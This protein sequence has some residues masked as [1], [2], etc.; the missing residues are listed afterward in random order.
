MRHPFSLYKEVKKSG[1]LWYARFWDETAQKY[2]RSRSTG[3]P[4]E[5]K[6]ER[7]REAEEAARRIY[8]ELTATLNQSAPAPAAIAPT[9]PAPQ[10]AQTA[11]PQQTRTTTAS[12][13]A[14]MPLTQYL[15]GFWTPTSEYAN[16]NRDV[17]KDPLTPYYIKS[18]HEDV[19][20]HVEP[21]P[22]FAGVTV[23]SLSKATLKKWLIWLASRKTQRRKKDGTLIEGDTLS[24]RRANKILQ[25][26]RVAVRW[27]V[28]NEEIP[29]DP[30]RK[31]GEV[32]DCYDSNCWERLV[33]WSDGTRE[34]VAGWT[35][36]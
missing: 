20:R 6:K 13:V 23:G 17:K 14:N 18:N 35:V 22:G 32:T 30:F 7:R 11:E 31:L 24:S 2:N 28:D 29:I 19:R 3:V 26:V 5:G 21:F 1:T 33:L 36:S 8:E 16:Y 34:P 10:Q 27:A 15:E 25:S 9:P 12:A 4:V